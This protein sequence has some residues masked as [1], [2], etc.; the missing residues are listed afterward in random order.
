LLNRTVRGIEFL[1]WIY[2]CALNLVLLAST[3]NF[4]FNN[5]HLGWEFTAYLNDLTTLL[6]G[7]SE[8]SPLL[9]LGWALLFPA[10][11]GGGLWYLVRRPPAPLAARNSSNARTVRPPV[12]SGFGPLLGV[13]LFLLG[14]LAL[15]LRGGWQENPLRAPDA[16]RYDTS[17]LNTVPLN[18]LFTITRDV[19]D[20]SDFIKFYDQAEN[21]RTVRAILDRP[22]AFRSPDYPLLRYMPP[23]PTPLPGSRPPNL[24][25]IILESFTAKYLQVHGGNPEIA[26]NLH[27]LIQQGRYYERFM[28]SGGRSANGIFCMMA[29]LP[30]RANRTILR[31]NE[32]QNR[33]GGVAALLGRKGYRSVFVHGGDL[34]FDSMDRMLPHLGFDEA[35]GWREM[36]A[37]GLVRDAERGAQKVSKRAAWGYHDGDSF[38]VLTDRMD[39]LYKKDSEGPFFAT[40]FTLN[41]HHPFLIPDESFAYFDSSVEQRDFLNSYRYTDH[42]LGEFIA[43]MRTRPY[44]QDTVFVIT[45][46][47]ASHR[48]LNYLEDRRIPLL[49]YAPGHIAPTRN[50]ELASQLDILPT[51]LG[52]A[53]G[54]TD[55][56]AMGNDLLAPRAARGG[57]AEPFVYYAGG[58]DTGVIGWVEEELLLMQWIGTPHFIVLTAREPA[59]QVNLYDRFPARGDAMLH[60]SR[61]FHQFARFL[62]QTNRIFPPGTDGG[63]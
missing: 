2:L 43:E 39:D 33:M 13:E 3:Y 31:S 11:V 9:L 46:D 12:W 59:D 58:S 57:Q 36:E 1:Q 62:E 28:A 24:V 21:T 38:R 52:L 63:N 15:A 42:A 34:R 16:I 54:D 37:Q 19:Q 61:H 8:R 30:D 40:I 48:D 10:L 51:L 35:L 56:A 23:R 47:H 29:G 41:T 60:K 17:Y 20:R 50:R 27:R 32:S 55:Y 22:E 6:G 44:F 14:L 18:G 25:L 26:P 5:K 49:L 45:A 7:I 53:G 4:T